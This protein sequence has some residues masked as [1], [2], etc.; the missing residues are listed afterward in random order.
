MKDRSD[1]ELLTLLRQNEQKAL[2]E[3]FRRYY[4]PLCEFAF[5]FVRSFDLT[6]EVVSDVFI[7][8]WRSRHQTEITRLKSYLYAATR[9]QA[10]NLLRKEGRERDSLDDLGEELLP[11]SRYPDQ[12]LLYKEFETRID[13]LINTLPPRRKLIFRLNRIEGFTYKEIAEMLSISVHT[14][15]NQMVEAV[16]QLGSRILND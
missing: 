13:A 6:E 12:E 3:L 5:H 14:V 8:I 15:Q 4:Y 2:E 10:L 7:K 16:K 1:E 9:N 11:L